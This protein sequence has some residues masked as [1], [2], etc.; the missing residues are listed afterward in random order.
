MRVTNSMM[1]TRTMRGQNNNLNRMNKWNHDLT[2][3]TNLHRPSDN[4]VKV[5]RTLRLESDIN[6]NVQYKDNADAAKSWLEKTESAMIEITSVVQRI[7]ELAVAGA[8][9]VLEGDDTQKIEQEVKELRDHLIQIGNDTYMGRH[10]FSGYETDKPLLQNDGTYNGALDIVNLKDEVIKYQVGDSQF[11]DVNIPGTKVFGDDGGEPKLLKDIKELMDALNVGDHAAASASIE[12]MDE[13]LR[14]VLQV[15][16]EV[17]SKVNM[18]DTMQER[19]A[20]VTINLKDLLSKT[21]DTDIAETM[22][23]LTSSEAVYRASLAVNARIIQP[24][25]IDFL[26]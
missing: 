20:D 16:G 12:K 2:T 21:R 11:V 17:G 6:L 24:T 15:R 19:M 14:T 13:N 26:R 7:R 1:I 22:I 8:N 23:Q 4:P 18:L 10:I 3:M 5:A 9:G 25:L